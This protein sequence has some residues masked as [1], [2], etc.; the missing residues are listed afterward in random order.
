MLARTDF[1]NI[2]NK[3]YIFMKNNKLMIGVLLL[4]AG[5]LFSCEDGLEDNLTEN[6]VYLVSSGLQEFEIYKTGEPT[7]YSMAV[8]KSGVAE[9][10][11]TASV[12]LCSAQEL[13]EYNT[14]N[15]TEYKLMTEACYQ[16]T[17]SSVSFGAGRNDVNNVIEIIFM[18]EAIEALGEDRY[19]LPVKLTEASID[20]NSDKAMVI[21][22]PTV[23]EPMIY[24]KSSGNN[25]N[26]G[27][28][29]ADLTQN[30]TI[31]FNASNTRN[32]VCNLAIDAE[33][34][35]T[36]NATSG[37]PFEL[38]PE[39]AF[40]LPASATI[41][42]DTKEVTAKLALAVSTLPIGNYLLP[43]RLSSDQFKVREGNDLY[44]VQIVV[45][46]PVLDT[47]KWTI[48]ANTEEPAES[49]PNGRAVAIID[50]DINSFWHS[51]WN[52]GWQEWPHI[53]IIDMKERSE[54]VSID[55][56]G[57]QSGGD[58][59]TKDMEFFVGDDQNTWRSIGKFEA[60]KTPDMQEFDTEDAAGRYLKIEITSSHDGSNNTNIAE[61]IVHGTIM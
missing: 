44:V 52:G 15:E 36:Y 41:V 32:I 34:L 35:E 42:E 16:M 38:L 5:A 18:P 6:K 59:N 57:R 2:L 3:L 9:A 21:L 51:Q 27:L 10:A 33:Y 28:G 56:Y 29:A 39:S 48:T 47:R 17:S 30:L 11:C 43:I 1:I 13:E 23:I 50:G 45:T 60:R 22:A 8:Y 7:T 55:Y 46:S 61:L 26:L 20:I 53:I 12:G 25:L 19:V 49:A 31:A 24:F 58:A 4:G 40:T 54:V 37:V 14:L